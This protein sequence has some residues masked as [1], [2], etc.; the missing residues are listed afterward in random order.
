LG[1]GEFAGNGKLAP[2]RVFLTPLKNRLDI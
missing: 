2:R 1:V